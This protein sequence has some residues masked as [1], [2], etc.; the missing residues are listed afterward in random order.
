MSDKFG[1][2]M[3]EKRAQLKLTKVQMAEKVGCSVHVI[4]HIEGSRFNPIGLETIKTLKKRFR[5]IAPQIEK[6]VAKRNKV[7]KEYYKELRARNAKK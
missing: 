7:A 6:T 5:G 2:L 4:N 1:E 3:K